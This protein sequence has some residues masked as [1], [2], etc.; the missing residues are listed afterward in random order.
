MNTIWINNGYI[1]RRIKG[2]DLDYHLNENW[3]VGQ[4]KKSKNF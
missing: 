2:E 3:I 1:N 4:K